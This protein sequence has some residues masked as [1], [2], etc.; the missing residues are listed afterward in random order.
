[1]ARYGPITNPGKEKS[2]GNRE[3]FAFLPQL[4]IPQSEGLIVNFPLWR[5][6]TRKF[7]YLEP[8]ISYLSRWSETSNPRNTF[9][10]SVGVGVTS[11]LGD[12]WV[13]TVVAGLSVPFKCL[14]MGIDDKPASSITA[15]MLA[16][17]YLHKLNFFTPSE[18][19]L[20]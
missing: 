18:R 13:A 19:L 7:C 6:T 10:D 16:I 5:M 9:R 15:S 3:R 12:L 4:A 1:L 8:I 2:L 20:T 14:A 17:L 11:E